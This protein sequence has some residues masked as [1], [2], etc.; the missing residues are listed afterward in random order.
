MSFQK[1]D[2]S[3]RNDVS[4]KSTRQSPFD[5]LEGKYGVALAAS[6]GATLA[7]RPLRLTLYVP[8]TISLSPMPRPSVNSDPYC[9]VQA[10]NA[11]HDLLIRVC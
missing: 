10:A 4:M 6:Q 2:G 8:T 9:S 11:T 3:L 7:R 5:G 1:L